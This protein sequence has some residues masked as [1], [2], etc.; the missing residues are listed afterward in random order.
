MIVSYRN[1]LSSA[2]ASTGNSVLYSK[3]AWPGNA[4]KHTYRVNYFYDMHTLNVIYLPA[5]MLI[6]LAYYHYNE[7]KTC[8][9]NTAA[10]SKIKP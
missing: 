10:E 2:A 4:H 9:K 5:P 3:S 1:I 8:I 7:P 6:A